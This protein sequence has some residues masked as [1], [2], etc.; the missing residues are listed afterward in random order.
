MSNPFE[1]GYQPQEIEA[2]WQRYWKENHTFRVNEASEKPKYYCLEMFPYPSGRIHMGHVRVYAIGDLI[3]RFK[4]MRGFQLLHPMGWDA[5]GLPA[6]NAAIKQNVPPAEWTLKNIAAMRLQLERLG[7]SYDWDREVTTC[8]PDYYRWNQWLFIKMFERGLAYQKEGSVNWC[9]SCET[10]LANEQVIEGACWRCASAVI[11]KRLNQWFLKISDYAE[12]LLSS[13]QMLTGWPER[14]LLMQKNWIGKSS[15]LEV[16]FPLF[17]RPEDRKEESLTIFTTRPDTLFGVTFL[18]IAPEHPLLP[19]LVSGKPEEAAV[20]SFIE[21]IRQQDKTVLTMLTQEKEG[22]FTG[23]YAIHPL[24]HEK[25]PIFTANFVLMEYGT[26]IIMAVPAHDQ[27]DFEFAAKYNLPIRLVIQNKEQ[28]LTLPLSCAYTESAGVLVNSDIFTGLTPDDA[29]TAIARYVQAEGMG[30]EKIYYRL[31]DWGVSRQ[32]YWG[33]PIPMVYCDTCG[34]VPV[35]VSNLPVRLPNDVPFSGK[36]TSPLLQSTSFLN[37]ACP[38]CGSPSRRE[39]DTMDTFFDSSWYF[40]RY[41]SPHETTN[42]FDPSQAAKWL[43]VTQYIGGIEHAI[44]HLLYARFFTK[45]IA[46]LGL[47][48][49]REPFSNLLTQGMVIKDNAKM[50]KS[51]GNVVDPDHLINEYGADTTRLFSLFAAPPEKDLVWSDEGVQGASRFLTRVCKMVCEAVVSNPKTALISKEAIKTASSGAKQ[52]YR[53]TQRTIKRV[54]EDT[55]QFCFNTAIS[56]LM[57]FYN[58]LSHEAATRS[59]VEREDMAYRQVSRD[60]IENLVVLISPFAPHLGE[61]LWAH[62][63]YA[64]S[65]SQVAWPQYDPAWV[66]EETVEVVVQVNGKNKAK[67]MEPAGTDEA[68]LKKKALSDAK[69]IAAIGDLPIKKIFVIQSRLINIVV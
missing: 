20:L 3:A 8:L 52:I 18:C 33:T 61:S 2:Y 41:V 46:D 30:A 19:T 60:A 68:V 67:F 38:K 47:T 63:G 12:E 32:R 4:T 27:R 59:A 14:V 29:K 55:E 44:L 25:I 50:S 53:M 36:G 11:Q 17:D 16:R 66:E 51:K 10:V 28:S 31:R 64:P 5:F 56:A 9:L 6:E 42:P 58:F 13:A 49:V 26:G 24:T 45:V 65:I 23:A 15:G 37:T 22:L 34:V 62:L 48:D 7:L 35:S 43:P 39:T 57:E 40:L 54:T 69:V 21:K 1:N